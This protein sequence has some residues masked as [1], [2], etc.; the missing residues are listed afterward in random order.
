MFPS[1]LFLQLVASDVSRYQHVAVT[2]QFFETVVRYAKYFNS[3]PDK[4]AS[5][6]VR[7]HEITQLHFIRSAFNA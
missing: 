6:L 2:K 5:V 3:E 4:I 1:S 7:M